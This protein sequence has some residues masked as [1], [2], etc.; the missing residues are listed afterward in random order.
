MSILFE[1][2][3]TCKRY[4]KVDKSLM[5]K[6]K[7]IGGK[8]LKYAEDSIQQR[9]LKTSKRIRKYVDNVSDVSK[10]LAFVSSL[11]A[12]HKKMKVSD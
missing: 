9:S 8:L 6:T 5:K 7:E 1:T 10:E 11:M 4:I 2:S 12:I 3:D